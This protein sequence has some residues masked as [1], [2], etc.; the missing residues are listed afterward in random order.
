MCAR[1]LSCS[2]NK[3]HATTINFPFPACR[4]VYDKAAPA[5]KTHVDAWAERVMCDSYCLQV[6]EYRARN[7]GT[8]PAV[9]AA[10]CRYVAFG[11]L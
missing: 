1:A 2:C 5:V 4:Y 11:V 7:T 3:N 6:C 8:D 9:C 10:D